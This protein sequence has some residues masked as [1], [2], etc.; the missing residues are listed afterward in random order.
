MHSL[1][2]NYFS[3]RV[4]KINT[5]LSQGWSSLFPGRDELSDY[6]R[7]FAN[8]Y[9]LH[10]L[11]SFNTNVEDARWSDDEMLW[12]VITKN[13]V[14]GQRTTW[15]TNVLVYAPGTYN[16]KVLPNVPGIESFKGESWHT[17][18]WPRNADLSG[19]V[20]AYVGSGPSAVQI[21]RSIQPT[22]K[23]LRVFVRSMTFNLPM[24][25]P[26]NGPT[27]QFL[28]KWVPGLLNVYAFILGYLFAFWTYYLFRPGT[29]IARSAEWYCA[30]HFE[31]E[32][33]DPVLRG[34][35][36]PVGRIGAKRPLVSTDFYK[37]LQEP[38]VEVVTDPITRIDES[39]VISVPK[40][41]R[42]ESATLDQQ[43]LGSSATDLGELKETLRTVD[44][45]IWGTGFQMQGWGTAF[46]IIGRN[47]KTLGQHW[48]SKP[49]TLYGISTIPHCISL[50]PHS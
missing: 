15:K 20:V 28:K 5:S 30:R 41:M 46:K 9:N 49:Q 6:Y 25:N 35:L 22:A 44:V 31:K 43:S 4:I 17:Y 24:G 1:I 19:K 42:K 26:Q 39:G 14:S 10:P 16:R 21:L 27:I 13:T 48:D 32:V 47:G 36:R 40:L 37:V 50:L 11:T 29:W 3:A 18:D 2:Q 34:Q 38:N 12:T 23:S 33:Q 45:L 8:K 7:T